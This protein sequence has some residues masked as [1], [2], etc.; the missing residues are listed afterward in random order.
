[1]GYVLLEEIADEVNHPGPFAKRI[2]GALKTPF[3]SSSSDLLSYLLEHCWGT[4]V[5]DFWTPRTD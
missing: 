3:T 1:M 5:A 2:A 4:Q